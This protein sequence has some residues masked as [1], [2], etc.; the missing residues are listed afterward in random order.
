MLLEFEAVHF[1][2]EDPF[3]RAAGLPS[4]TYN[5]CRKILMQQDIF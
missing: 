5:D 2:A 3:T 1:D 4:P